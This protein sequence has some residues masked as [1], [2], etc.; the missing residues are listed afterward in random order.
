MADDDEGSTRILPDR[1]NV[2]RVLR[3]DIL[4]ALIGTHLIVVAIILIRG[5]GWLQPFE[6][7][8]YDQLR[9]AWA[10]H[11]PNARILLIGGTEEDLLRWNWPL[12]DGD[13][14]TLLERSASWKPR[15]IGVDLY[16]DRPE[17]PGTDHTDRASH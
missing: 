12:R 13:L 3:S 4:K 10:G 2:V 11:E 15:V 6:L 14:A 1:N 17:P 7:A 9:V 8:I 5:Q 16:R